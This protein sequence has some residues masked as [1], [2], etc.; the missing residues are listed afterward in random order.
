[1]REQGSEAWPMNR[2]IGT[3]DA[4]RC[5]VTVRTEPERDEERRRA[6]RPIYQV[7]SVTALMYGKA[8]RSEPRLE[9]ETPWRPRSHHGAMTE[10]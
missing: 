4:A 5:R 6:R 10:P 7:T 8:D 2:T 9:R 1:M 3:G